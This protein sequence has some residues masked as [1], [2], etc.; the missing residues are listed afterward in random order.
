MSLLWEFD[1]PFFFPFTN[2]KER[3]GAG[4]QDYPSPLSEKRGWVNVLLDFSLN[5]VHSLFLSCHARGL[6]ASHRLSAMMTSQ[7]QQRTSPA[8][9]SSSSLGSQGTGS[10]GEVSMSNV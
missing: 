8:T 7:S 5:C 1:R 3:E 4:L 10:G 2:K 9:S 6:C